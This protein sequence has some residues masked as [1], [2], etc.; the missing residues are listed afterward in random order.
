VVERCLHSYEVGRTPFHR[1]SL[2][3]ARACLWLLG[4]DPDSWRDA[5]W[6]TDLYKCSTFVESP[7]KIATGGFAACRP[8]LDA[9]LQYFR[10]DVVLALGGKVADRMKR[11]EITGG[12][13]VVKFD[14]P[15]P[16][17]PYWGRLTDTRHAP[18][19]ASIAD[20]AAS[21]RG[22]VWTDE[23]GRAFANFLSELE[24]GAR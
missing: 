11:A 7:P 20:L 17:N 3:L 8:W 6:F 1:R 4:V 15:S 19:F 2:K 9:E 13:A 24:A 16:A 23:R 22:V 18:A 14:H 21:A 12:P 10:P 5:V